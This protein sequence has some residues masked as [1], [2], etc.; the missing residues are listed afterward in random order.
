MNGHS[1]SG[2]A[3]ATDCGDLSEAPEKKFATL[4]LN[5]GEPDG[6][7]ADGGGAAELCGPAAG[8]EPV[9]AGA[10]ILLLPGPHPPGVGA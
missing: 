9:V 8:T 4:S 7:G 2:C 3:L 5:E 10:P 6:A 1:T